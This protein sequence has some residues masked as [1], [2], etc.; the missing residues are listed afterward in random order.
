MDPDCLK[1]KSCRIRQA[2]L[3]AI[4]SLCRF[5]DPVEGTQRLH[6]PFFAFAQ[7]LPGDP[8][9]HRL[10]VHGREAAAGVIPVQTG[11]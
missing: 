11:D 5:A 4:A 8:I 7:I 6:R 9:P 10:P 1:T 3:M 2:H